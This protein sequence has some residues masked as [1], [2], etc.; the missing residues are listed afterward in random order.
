MFKIVKNKKPT[1][2]FNRKPTNAWQVRG[3]QQMGDENSRRGLHSGL[4]KLAAG[5]SREL[6]AHALLRCRRVQCVSVKST[7][8][9]SSTQL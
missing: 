3:Q 6:D 5:A 4:R 1:K 8:V 2:S 7:K 9:A